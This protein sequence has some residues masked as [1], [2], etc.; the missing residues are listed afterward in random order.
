MTFQVGEKVVYPNH[1]V[2]T[3]E[4]ITTRPSGTHFE[5]FYLLR[6]SY[7]S[8][9]VMVPFSHVTDVG[10]RKVTR[11]AEIA[12]VLAFLATGACRSRQD[13]KDRFKENSVKMQNGSLLEI[14]EVFKQLLILQADK[15]LSFREKKMLDR[16]RQMLV[17]EV[18]ACRQLN[19][20]GAV[21]LLRRSLVKSSLTWPDPL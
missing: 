3:I 15:P 1:G 13:W 19:E 2:G 4:N 16:A 14:A 20:L 18:C 17:A 6:L 12:R 21:D 5:K 7:N 8:M 10:L 11:A 9:T